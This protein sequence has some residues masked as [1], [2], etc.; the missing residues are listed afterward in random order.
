M[1]EPYEWT[2]TT[3]EV[4][5]E[6]QMRRIKTIRIPV[7]EAKRTR[8]SIR[9]M[10]SLL[11]A[12]ALLLAWWFPFSG[13]SS[14]STPDSNTLKQSRDNLDGTASS[15]YVNGKH[16]QILTP[17]TSCQTQ[18]ASDTTTPNQDNGFD[19]RILQQSTRD[20]S[21]IKVLKSGS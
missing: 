17:Q 21:H 7:R 16:I 18:D 3:W 10:Q 4:V 13:A 2:R 6:R 8:L 5:G 20:T 11:V 14:N 19:Q 9:I 1:Y 12:S 15:L